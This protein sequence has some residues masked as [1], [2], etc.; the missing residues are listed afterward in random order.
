MNIIHNSFWLSTPDYLELLEITDP[1]QQQ[2]VH[3]TVL[4]QVLAPS[5]KY[6]RHLCVNRYSIIDGEQSRFFLE[7]LANLLELS[8]SSHPTM[9]FVLCL[10]VVLTIP[11]CLTFFESERSIWYF[12]DSMVDAQWDW[13]TKGGEQ[14]QMWKKILRILR[15]EG[16]DDVVESKL[17]NDHDGDWTEYVVEESITWNNLQAM[18]LPRRT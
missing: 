7:L 18:N 1:D 3:E 14:R 10:P 2:A 13:N 9:D 5:E 12:L 6:I 16:I 8:P 17:Q 11:S 4:K 15:M